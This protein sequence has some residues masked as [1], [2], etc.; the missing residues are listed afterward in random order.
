MTFCYLYIVYIII[1][2]KN[3]SIKTAYDPVKYF[4]IVNIHRW[5]N[6]ND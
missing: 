3:N 6:W 5:D 4:R 1:F 2:A